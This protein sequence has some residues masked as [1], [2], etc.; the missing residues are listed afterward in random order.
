MITSLPTT[1]E[2]LTGLV[3]Q[4][5][6]ENEQLRQR[7]TE[8]ELKLKKIKI[9]PPPKVKPNIPNDIS[10][11]K[12]RKQR[13]KSYVRYRSIPDEVVVHAYCQCPHCGTPVTGDSLAYEREI[14]DL[15][16][17]K[18]IVTLHKIIKRHC[19]HCGQ[20]VTPQVNFS[21]LALGQSRFGVGII[22]LITTL[23]ERGRL[24]VRVIRHLLKC[25][26]NLSVSNGEIIETSHR[27]A[28][29][30]Q[31]LYQNLRQS[32]LRSP[33]IHADETG[34]RENG[35][36][37]YVW[38]FTT[39]KIRY[40]VYCLSRKGTVVDEVL[41][42]EFGGVLTTDFYA[43][44]NHVSTAH[45]RCWAHLLCKLRQLIQVYSQTPSV[46]ELNL[47]EQKV[48][49]FYQQAKKVQRQPDLNLQEKHRERRRL[50]SSILRLV[51]PYLKQKDHPFHT[52]AKRIDYYLDELF[53]FVLNPNL[54]STN[55]PAERAVRH[56]V[57]KR[58]I[59]GGTRSKKGSHTQEVITTLFST[60]DL[61]HLNPL[62]ECRKLLTQP[63]YATQFVQEL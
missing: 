56:Q 39:P 30:G 53:T 26:F 4:L 24:P 44:Y 6:Q 27:L 21:E 23:R 18:P 9:N 63:H 29:K 46:P 19:T 43:A 54:D 52:L 51:K 41:G 22:G 33:V 2:G 42:E 7:I 15:P 14:I 34:H 5:A 37:G 32:L 28:D 40:Y 8:L 55:N 45:Q 11:V 38:N 61:N 50:E 58:K 49:K 25:L 36:N 13:V 3:H 16:P 12:K 48:V 62:E 1:V 35:H 10:S 47:I 31:D 57:I 20:W 60:W 17:V 59:S